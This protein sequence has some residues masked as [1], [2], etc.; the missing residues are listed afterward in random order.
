MSEAAEATALAERCVSTGD[1]GPELRRHVLEEVDRLLTRVLGGAGVVRNSE[2]VDRARRAP[3][4]VDT[5]STSRR[6]R[7]RNCRERK[8]QTSFH[9]LFPQESMTAPAPCLREPSIQPSTPALAAADITALAS[10][11]AQMTTIPT[12]M[13]NV[14][15]ISAGSTA[16][17]SINTLNT[18]G[19][20]QLDV[21]T[22]ASSVGGSARIRM[23]G[24]PPA[25]QGG[26]G[27]P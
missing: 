2:T 22:T 26:R 27:G 20:F 14:R 16:P 7:Q 24:R 1:G 21:S 23:A 6:G 13:L 15:R 3:L 17:A 5:L 25:R 12:P 4:S 9:R 8:E 11:G 10:D 18:F 19:I